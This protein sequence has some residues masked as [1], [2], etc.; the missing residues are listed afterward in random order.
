MSSIGKNIR[1]IRTVKKLSQAAFAEI[2][3][4]ARPSV[5][6][7][8]EERAEPKV[9]TIIQIANHF[10]ISIDSLLQKELTINDLY[11]FN[12]HLSEGIKDISEKKVADY[13]SNFIKTVLVPVEKQHEYI[14][15]INN[16]DFISALPKI[17]IPNYHHKNIRAFEMNSNDMYYNSQGLGSGDFIFGKKLVEPLKYIGD[18]IYAIVTNE[19]VIIRRTKSNNKKIELIPDNKDY[20]TINI[21]RTDVIEAWEI[22]GYFSSKIE[23]PTLVSDRIL[24]LEHQFDVLNDRLLIVEKDKK[25]Q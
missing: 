14:V 16:R 18:Q 24:Q 2:F 11:N 17:M 13:N 8:E 3:N 10:G 9:D 19:K 4:L 22:V 5:G 1:K 12:V 20:K 25:L 15:H 21:N 23:P 6:A 7:Y